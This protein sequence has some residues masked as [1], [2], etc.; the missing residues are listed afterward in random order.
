WSHYSKH[1]SDIYLQE[2]IGIVD[3]AKEAGVPLSLDMMETLESVPEFTG[4]GHMEE[5]LGQLLEEPE[6]DINRYGTGKIGTLHP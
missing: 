5:M 4:Y 3:G 2:L 1:T 6:E